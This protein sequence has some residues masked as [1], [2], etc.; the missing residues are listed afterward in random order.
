MFFSTTG[1]VLLVL[2]II[3][4]I[5]FLSIDPGYGWTKSIDLTKNYIMIF[6]SMA[7]GMAGVV[8]II[9]GQH[10]NDL[11][12]ESI[13]AN[14]RCQELVSGNVAKVLKKDWYSLRDQKS[15]KSLRVYLLQKKSDRNDYKIIATFNDAESKQVVQNFTITSYSIPQPITVD[16]DN[17]SCPGVFEKN[18]SINFDIHQKLNEQIQFDLLITITE[19]TVP[20]TDRAGGE[21]TVQFTLKNESPGTGPSSNTQIGNQVQSILNSV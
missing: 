20:E 7:V 21:K 1:I 4:F 18:I 6:T 10:M 8:L 11:H 15:K 5:F 13:K 17:L 2:G 3:I 12:V 9:S 16:R 19:D 14:M